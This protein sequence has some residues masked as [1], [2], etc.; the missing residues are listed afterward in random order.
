[1]SQ[2]HIHVLSSQKCWGV[3]VIF[4]LQCLL[5]KTNALNLLIF[6]LCRECVYNWLCDL[7][8]Y[9]LWQRVG[10]L[11]ESRARESFEVDQDY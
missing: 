11:A 2:Y 6:T 10:K 8:I 9:Q 7:S 4:F 5:D 3:F 1:M